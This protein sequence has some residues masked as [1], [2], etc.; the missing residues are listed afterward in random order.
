MGKKPEKL[1]GKVGFSEKYFHGIKLIS[2]VGKMV[3]VSG[4]PKNP[5]KVLKHGVNRVTQSLNKAKII[6]LTL[7]P[8]CN[9]VLKEFAGT[10]KSFN[11]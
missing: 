7:S 3:F 5:Q 9:S 6:C 4:K 11:C 2:V 8:T 1:K 10:L